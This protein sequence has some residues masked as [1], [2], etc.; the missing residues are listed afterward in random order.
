VEVARLVDPVDLAARP[1]TGR[2]YVATRPGRVYSIGPGGR[3]PRLELDLGDEVHDGDAP[4]GYASESGMLGIAFSPSGA[5]MYLTYTAEPPS[6][7]GMDWVLAEYAVGEDGVD[8]SSRRELISF[9]KRAPQHNAGDIHFG[10]DGLLY[11]STGDASPHGDTL[12]TGQDTTDLLGAI[13]RIDPRPSGEAPYTVPS[14]NPFS[15]DG[16]ARP[17][18][19]LYG[20][21]NPWRFSFDRLRGDLWV[22]DVGDNVAEEVTVL[23][24]ARGGGRGANLGWSTYEGTVRVRGRALTGAE[25]P[26]YE[27]GHEGPGCA[28]IGGYVYRGRA[29]PRL[30]GHYVFADHCE[31]RLR[32]LRSTGGRWAD[33]DLGIEIPRPTAFGEDEDGELYVLSLD[34]VILRLEPA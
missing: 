1:G 14:G 2:L 32:A 23:P 15:A 34:G 11:V 17:E 31:G 30:R 27:Y 21:R 24:R 7:P 25:R 5:W 28:I 22:T 4:P 13:L 12:G 6:G 10:P 8:A 20:L 9:F 18:I 26:A 33:Y 29:L 19:W 16:D 3:D